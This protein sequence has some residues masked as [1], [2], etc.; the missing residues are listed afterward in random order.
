MAGSPKCILLALYYVD[1]RSLSNLRSYVTR[2]ML[3]IIIHVAILEGY[4]GSQ[5][6]QN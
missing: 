2:L 3:A 4:R 6:V 1:K 5:H